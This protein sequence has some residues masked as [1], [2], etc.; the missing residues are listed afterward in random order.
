MTEDSLLKIMQNKMVGDNL[1]IN[2][3]MKSAERVNVNFPSH[4][5]NSFKSNLLLKAKQQQFVVG[6]SRS[7]EVNGDNGDLLHGKQMGKQQKQ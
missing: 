1:E 6:F 5:K 4:Y 2:K 7:I 3:L